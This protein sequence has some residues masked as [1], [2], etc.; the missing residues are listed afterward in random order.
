[1]F[2]WFFFGFFGLLCFGFD[3]TSKCSTPLPLLGLQRSHQNAAAGFSSC[4]SCR[5]SPTKVIIPQLSE[6]S[7]LPEM[8]AGLIS[9]KFCGSGQLLSLRINWSPNNQ[10]HK[11]KWE[12][13]R[14]IL[15]T[16][17]TKARK[18][19]LS[20]LSSSQPHPHMESRRH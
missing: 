12:Q 20:S 16:K 13:R 3:F 19:G 15:L 2:C 6:K 14:Q 7:L 5:C 8:V 18:C 10:K 17:S 11:S 4:L 1:M 9:L